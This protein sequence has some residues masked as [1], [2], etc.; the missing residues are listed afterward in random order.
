MLLTAIVFGLAP[1]LQSARASLASVLKD[2]I[3]HVAGG[4]RHARVR[5]GLVVAQVALSVL[6]VA[7]AGLF[8]RSLYDLRSLDP[9]FGPTAC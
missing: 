7:G 4:P 1:A 6:L 5:K 9:G 8:A 3:G 2:E